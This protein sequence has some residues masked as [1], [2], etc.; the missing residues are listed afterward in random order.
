MLIKLK[1]FSV[2][3]FF[4]LFV[5]AIVGGLV[6]L[7]QDYPIAW[8]ILGLGVIWTSYLIIGAIKTLMLVG[9]IYLGAWA[10]QEP[11]LWLIW[12]IPIVYQVALYVYFK[13][14]DF[15][16]IL[17]A[18]ESHVQECNE[19]NSHITELKSAYGYIYALNQGESSI[20][21]C[22]VFNRRRKTWETQTYSPNVY[23]ASATVCKNANNQP[24]KYLC[25]YFNLPI[26]KTSLAILEY[27]LNSFATVEQGRP[28]LK[29]KQ[30]ELFKEIRRF[31]PIWV[32]IGGKARILK[33]LGFEPIEINDIYFPTYTFKYISA[34]GYS[35]FTVD[36]E[37]NLP[38]LENMIAYINGTLAYRNSIEGQRTLM[39]TKLREAIKARDNY[40]CKHCGIST[41]K[42][43]HLLLEIDHVIPVSKGGQT[44]ESNLQTLCWKCNRTKGAKLYT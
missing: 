25:K 10:A 1:E 27:V 24:Y 34:G 15:R 40:T 36:I 16:T 28:L 42:E 22:S 37:L 29:S 38:N 2:I 26:T 21:D 17:D 7:A 44:M 39:T 20:Q 6:Y 43:P 5:G 8:F 30:K 11:I 13:G 31:I 41:H 4:I 9:W 33:E 23:Y 14:D 18:V 19:L 12:I 3:L 32:K 35:S